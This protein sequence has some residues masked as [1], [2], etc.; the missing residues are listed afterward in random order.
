MTILEAASEGADRWALPPLSMGEFAPSFVLPTATNPNFNF[1]TVA[2]RYVLLAFMPA[3]PAAR[4]AAAAAFEAV[5][6][7]F[8][9]PRMA[10][11]FVATDPAA[12]GEVQDSLPGQRWFFDPEDQAGPLFD[13]GAAKPAWFLLDPQLRVLERA[14]I[15]APRPLFVRLEQL[16]PLGEHAGVPL[17]APVLV[18]PRVFEPEFC[19]R[20][21]D[22]YEARGG[23]LSGVM[24]DIDGR[25][26]G[27]LDNMKR[28]RDVIIEDAGLRREVVTRLQRALLPMIARTFHFKVTRLERYLI[29]CYDSA[30]GGFFQAHRDNETFGTAHRR[31]AC[32]INLNAEEFEGGDVRF[33]EYGP[34]TYR[35]P[36]GGAVVFACGLQHE[37]TPVTR[38]RRF[39]FLPFLFDEADEKLREANLAR[40]A[41]GDGA[42]IDN[43]G[44]R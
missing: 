2:G 25:T 44:A 8:D 13:S 37:A 1:N 11:F 12:R 41:T 27:V 31:F 15:D 22:H 40:L 33:P 3:D 19:R 28:R 30:E 34:R 32:S 24:R 35:P 17:I 43:R 7:L 18:C 6:P 39:A 23:Q 38:G 14:P 26:V 21:I 29:A 4:A 5:R 20:L 10:A 16:P 42:V 36:T 9:G